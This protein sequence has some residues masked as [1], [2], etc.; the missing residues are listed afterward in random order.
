MSSQA[1]NEFLALSLLENEIYT[2]FDDFENLMILKLCELLE[3]AG[4]SRDDLFEKV[5]M[6]YGLIEQV[7]H[8]YIQKKM[9]AEVLSTMNSFAISTIVDL[10]EK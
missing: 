7:S 2:L 3:Q 10:L 5:K 6:S 8:Y 4:L 9:N 1:H